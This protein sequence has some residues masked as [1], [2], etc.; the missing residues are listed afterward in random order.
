MNNIPPQGVMFPMG[1]LYVGDLHQDVTEGMLYEKFSTAGQVLSLRI[2]RDARTKQSLGYGY[3]NFNS[4]EDAERALDTMNFDPLKGKPIRIMWCQRDPSLRKSGIGNVFIK[5]LDKNIDNKAM[6][7]TFSAFGNI[8][9]CKVALDEAGYSKGYGFVHFESEEIANR[10]IEKV[11]GMLLNEKTV[12]VGKFVPRIEREKAL[13]E[14]AKQF[15]NIYVKN[16]GQ[17]MS[18]EQFFEIFSKFGKVTSSMVARHPD[19]SSKGFGFVAYEDPKAAEKAVQE[20]NG[21]EFEGRTLYVGRAQKKAERMNELRKKY[22]QQR[23]ERFSKFQGVNV[24][25]KNLDDSFTDERLKSEFECFGNITSAKVMTE[26]GRSR[27]FGFVCFSAPDEANKAIHEMN[28]KIVGSKPL[29][30]ALA[31]RKEARR[32]LLTSQYVARAQAARQQ[33]LQFAGGPPFLIP[34]VAQTPRIYGPTPALR[35]APRWPALQTM[36]RP[37]GAFGL[38]LLGTA[39]RA[40]A[41]PAPIRQHARPITARPNSKYTTRHGPD[42]PMPDSRMVHAAPQEQKQL[43][44]EQLFRI[45][46]KLHP[47]MAGKITGMLLEIDNSEL[48]H[49]IKNQESL[50]AKV[51]EAIAVLEAHKANKKGMVIQD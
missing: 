34:A 4:P 10:A 47:E 45:V 39:Y 5:N 18:D 44:G 29:Y 48:L 27:G 38:P 50:R 7:D 31:Q 23:M 26:N 14:K 49:M 46:E 28:G 12:Y 21:S 16:F 6:Y 22:E 1:S 32:A 33:G 40:P 30:V 11:N 41:R 36:P 17:L 9:S 43:L 3:V 2:C 24:Y 51:E 35:P 42:S 13:G 8:L 20:M 19:K 15:T 25:I 37:N